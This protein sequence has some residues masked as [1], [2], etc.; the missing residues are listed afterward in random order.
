LHPQQR[1]FPV[2]DDFRN[3]YDRDRDR[4]LHS[5]SF[6]RLEHKT[7]VFLNNEGDYFRTRLTHSL[8]VSQIARSVSKALSL[9]ESLSEAIALSHDLGH[10]PFGHSGGDELDKVL[11]NSGFSNGFEHNY[12]SFRVVTK[13]EK[14]YK[15]FDGLNLCFATLESILKHSYPYNK[16]FLPQNIK[17]MFSLDTHPLLEAVVV[18][19]SDEIAYISHDIDDGIKYKLITFDD[20]QESRL[21][22]DIVSRLEKNGLAK[23]DRLFKYKFSATLINELVYNL[24]DNSKKNDL[25]IFIDAK[26]D[27]K[28]CIP[29][30]FS[31]DMQKEISNIKK[32]LYTKLYRHELIVKKMFLAKKCINALFIAYMDEQKLIPKNFWDRFKNHRPNHRV[33]ADY[34]AGMSDR[35]ALRQYK[36]LYTGI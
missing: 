33:V 30:R 31:S 6:R 4:V 13:L 5:S 32:I 35:Y 29:I 36:D 12:Q 1:F 21:V 9:D 22:Q 14:R 17:D 16:K 11:K 25:S 24:L 10:T 26:I 27:S 7:Q 2:D 18:D 8:E 19:K 3:P 20:L 23:S 28:E 15:D 34:I